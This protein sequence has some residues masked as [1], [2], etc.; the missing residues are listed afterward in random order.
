MLPAWIL[1]RHAAPYRPGDMENMHNFAVCSIH[2]S[3]C[4]IARR[5]RRRF[6]FQ[7]YEGIAGNAE[8]K[9]RVFT[10]WITSAFR[11]H[12]GPVIAGFICYPAEGREG[13]IVMS[14][15]VVT[16]AL[17]GAQIGVDGRY[18]RN[19]CIA[20]CRNRAVGSTSS[21]H[22]AVCCPDNKRNQRYERHDLESKCRHR[23]I[24]TGLSSLGCG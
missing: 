9:R 5:H 10:T 8:K 20:F 21:L 12:A 1:P 15:D 22:D 17:D 24:E 19:M 3:G 4:W 13:L 14:N 16:I 2:A 6:G 18:A 11:R 7:L 23:R